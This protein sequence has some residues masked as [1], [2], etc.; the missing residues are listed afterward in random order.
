MMPRHHRSNVNAFSLVEMPR[1]SQQRP[2]QP[3]ESPLQHVSLIGA[4]EE[5]NGEGARWRLRHYSR[6]R[7]YPNALGAS[8]QPTQTRQLHVRL[9]LADLT[10]AAEPKGTTEKQLE[11]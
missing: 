4:T 1:G 2:T 5:P 7:T 6:R 9:L 11:N 3:N 10:T 8:D